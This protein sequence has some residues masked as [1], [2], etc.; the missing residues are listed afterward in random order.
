[1]IAT[2]FTKLVGATAP[3]QLAA[4]PGISTL[5][6]VAAVA[7]AGGLGMLG[8]P[9]MSPAVLERAL[10]QLSARTR[11]AFGVNFLV[12]FLD[13]ACVSVAARRARVVEFFYGEPDAELVA[14]ARAFGALVSWQV[15]SL[16]EAKAAERAGCDFLVVQGTEA[17]GHVRGKTSLLPLLS[18]VLDRARVPVVAAGGI[19]TARS[20]AAVL[21]C[22]GGAARMGTRFV[23][24]TESGAHPAYVKAL[25]SSSAAD[26]CLTEAF[27]GM[28][29]D[30]PHRVLRSS[31]ARA[32][33]LADGVI[34]EAR[35]GDQ[36]IPIQRFSVIAPTLETTGQIDA[37]ALYAGESVGDVTT[38][39]PAAAIVADLVAGAER[40]LREGGALA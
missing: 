10:D 15:G 33:A 35:L 17:G 38:V 25:L 39:A 21:A 2:S 23:A 36:V 26:T 9:M 29:P 31:I 19:A 7:D 30:A 37:M 27:S 28:W 1:V 6:L 24:A 40:L 14:R 34:G 4:M 12:P 16:A 20:L 11:G 5:D 32:E 13:P 8:A 22:G 3:I 18:G